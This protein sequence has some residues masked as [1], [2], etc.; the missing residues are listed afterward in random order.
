MGFGARMS[1]SHKD[2]TGKVLDRTFVCTR[3]GKRAKD[4]RDLKVRAPRAETR[5]NCPAVMKVNC[6]LTG[7]YRVIRFVA[8]HNHELSDPSMIHMFRAH[9]KMTDNQEAEGYTATSSGL[10]LNEKMDIDSIDDDFQN[11]LQSKRTVEMRLGDAGCMM[12]YL[13]NMQLE[14]PN[15][16]YAIQVDKY[17]LL[18]N[19]FWVD[20]KMKADY[21]HFGDVVCFDTTYRRNKEGRPISLF[22]G[23]NHHKQNVI[24]GVVLL[25]DETA[26]T[27]EWLFDT[28]VKVMGRQPTTILTD[29]DEQIVKALSLQWPKTCHRLCVWQIHQ[30]ATIHLSGVF[31]KFEEFAKD[32]S[33]CMYDCEEEEEFT[34]SWH[35]ML[36]SYDL[37]DNE[38]LQRMFSIKERWALV[39]ERGTFCADMSN[40]MRKEIINSFIKKHI[41]YK[42]NLVQFFQH[43]QKFLDNCRFKELTADFNASQS[44]PVISLPVQIL[45]HAATVYTPEVFEQFKGE[46][47]KGYDCSMDACG[48]TEGICEYKITPFGKQHYHHLV[49]F[50]S[51]NESISCSC[52][53]FESVG[54]LCSHALKVLSSRSIVRIPSQYILTRWTK[55]AK[56]GNV[57]AFGGSATEIDPKEMRGF[58][59]K[60]LCQLYVQ[61]VTK[62]SE[63]EKAHKIAKLGFWKILEEVEISLE[64]R[65]SEESSSGPSL[66]ENCASQQIENTLSDL[67]CSRSRETDVIKRVTYESRKKQ[68]ST[69]ERATKKR[70]SNDKGRHLQDCEDSDPLDKNAISQAPQLSRARMDSFAV[71]L[72]QHQMPNFVQQPRISGDGL[73]EDDP[74]V[75]LILPQTLQVLTS[76][77]PPFGLLH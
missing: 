17:D 77:K 67:R 8:E 59:Y 38:W 49:T 9:R 53:K 28:F 16:F 23:V 15:F 52:K 55:K 64:E 71:Q 11:R 34:G 41:G 37:Q 51:L 31:A 14:D 57:D 21:A 76:R 70:K 73:S 69:S 30:Q 27:F 46:L 35:E 4:K 47:C 12:E 2:K 43:F 54:V 33:R 40:I 10:W 68:P 20:A 42:H 3:E 44:T 13:Q 58:R 25:Y 75:Q 50:H 36:N 32:L 65:E 62:A 5:C 7:R 74:T 63:T 29:E 26:R 18:T 22:V 39:Y 66:A 48:E 1:K 24:F 60:N 61:L 72:F 45:K 6:R 56:K 19:I